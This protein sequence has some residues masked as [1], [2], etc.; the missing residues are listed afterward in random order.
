MSIRLAVHVGPHK[1][2][3]TSVQRALVANRDR[4]VQAGVW[5][6]PSLAYAQFPDQ[7]AD[8]AGLL[9][10]DGVDSVSDWILRT[11][12]EAAGLGCDTLLLSSENFRAPLIRRQLRKVLRR[13]RRRTGG[14]T[15]LLYVRRD[16]RALARSQVMA[17]L[18]GELGFFF[19]ERYDLRTWAADFF[20][21]QR[22]EERFFT[23]E[24]AL[25]LCLETTPPHALAAHLLRLA[26]DKDFPFVET[27]RN[28]VTAD[29]LAGP[30]AVMLAYGLRVMQKV[31]E[32]RAIVGNNAAK[33][34]PLVG[35][36]A[37]AGYRELLAA[38]EATL[39]TA[40]ESGFADAE[41]ET[42]WHYRWRLLRRH[43]QE[44]GRLW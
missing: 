28:N 16:P 38:F 19:R 39:A 31:V 27:A 3:S 1:T 11:T 36:P 14:D 13:Y 42:I 15:R 21:Q 10:N 18:D 40:I 23:S 25:F 6:P 22:R 17:R 2:G 41:R 20:H 34:V 29:R 44:V 24:G 8:I 37:A 26:T 9:V 43:L 5:Y 33:A 7:H 12:R 35:E 30:P 32:G 4:L